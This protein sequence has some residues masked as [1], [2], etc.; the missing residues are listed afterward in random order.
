MAPQVVDLR[1][2]TLAL[3]FPVPG[4]NVNNAL[5]DYLDTLNV[6]LNANQ[7]C[8]LFG[9]HHDTLYRWVREQ[10]IPAIDIGRE[11]KPLLRFAP[12]DLANWAREAPSLRGPSRKICH[13]IE[14]QVRIGGPRRRPQLLIKLFS[15]TGYDWLQAAHR[16]RIAPPPNTDCSLLIGDL[17]AAINKLTI[18]EQRQLLADIRSGICDPRFLPVEDAE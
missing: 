14:D 10:E 6:P 12:K 5:A 3:I 11:S 17:F 2:P 13:W 9:L 15:L 8:D 18:D 1:E 7:V 4:G 16:R